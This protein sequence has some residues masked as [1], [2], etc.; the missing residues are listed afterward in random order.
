RAL[1]GALS[2]LDRPSE[3]DE[4]LQRASGAAA[5]AA[6]AYGAESVASW[7]REGRDVVLAVSGGDLVEHGV[8]PGPGIG[9]A[10]ARVRSELLDRGAMDADEQLALALAAARGES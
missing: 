5:V 4:E 7:W 2:G 8:A 1:A 9:R 3:V 10:L 6:L